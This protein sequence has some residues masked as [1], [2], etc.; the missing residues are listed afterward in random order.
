MTFMVMVLVPIA[1][2]GPPRLALARRANFPQP[3]RRMNND[4]KIIGL[5]RHI[6][7]MGPIKSY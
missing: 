7:P 2:S 5:I 4:Y 6:S 3:A 1:S